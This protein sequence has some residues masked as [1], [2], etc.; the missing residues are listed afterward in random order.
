MTYRLVRL[1]A[2]IALVL[3]PFGMASAPA[4][5]QIE[6]HGLDAGHCTYDIERETAPDSQAQCAMSCTMVVP[7]LAAAE[8][9]RFPPMSQAIALATPMTDLGPEIGT[10][11][12]KLL[13]C[14]DHP[15]SFE[16]Q[17]IPMSILLAALAL[18]AAPADQPAPAASAGQ[19]QHAQ[20]LQEMKKHHDECRKMMEKMHSGMKGSQPGDRAEKHK[21]HGSHH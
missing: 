4:I 10:P 6:H 15:R 13:D 2:V 7:S 5:A 3:M 16:F 12:P 17:E 8:P 9:I 1:F 11:P 18:A 14:F 20:H 21:S 19:A